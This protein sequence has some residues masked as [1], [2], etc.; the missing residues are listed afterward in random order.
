MSALLVRFKPLFTALRLSKTLLVALWALTACRV[1]VRAREPS[2]LPSTTFD[3]VS[4]SHYRRET[5]TARFVAEHTEFS[6]LDHIRSTQTSIELPLNHARVFAPVLEGNLL[7][8]SADALSP[9]RIELND[10]T[11]I[12]ATRVHYQPDQDLSG[13]AGVLIVSDAGLLKAASFQVNGVTGQAVF[14]QVST[15]FAALPERHGVQPKTETK[16]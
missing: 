4:I 16:R 2:S 10:G 5:L 15:V 1:E 11:V 13:D 14:E 3:G 6:S 9:A 8:Q 12:Y 7:E